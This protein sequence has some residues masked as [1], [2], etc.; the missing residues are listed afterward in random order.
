ME[1]APNEAGLLTSA[2]SVHSP[3]DLNLVDSKKDWEVDQVLGSRRYRGKVQYL[4]AWK[5]YP[6]SWHPSKNLS[7]CADLVRAFQHLK[8]IPKSVPM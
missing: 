5:G 8:Q 7:N 4:V 6:P 3:I 1:C 2:A